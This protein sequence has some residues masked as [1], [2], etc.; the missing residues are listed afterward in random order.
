MRALNVGGHTV[1]MEDLRALFSGLGLANVESFIA[2]GNII[3]DAPG[4]SVPKLERKIEAH[5][6]AALGYAVATFLRTPAELA[7]VAAHPAFDPA[8]VAKA[9]SLHIMFVGAAPSAEAA[10]KVAALNDAVNQ[11]HLHGRE[12]YWLR[13]AGQDVSPYSGAHLEKA[14]GMAGTARNITTVRKLVAKYPA[15]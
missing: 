15:G 14:L 12:L 11:F 2:S 7:A 4:G 1:K 3:F 6:E 8:T 9:H 13:Q 10:N 5:L